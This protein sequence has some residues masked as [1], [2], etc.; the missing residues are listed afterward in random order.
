MKH[1]AK[2][3]NSRENGRTWSELGICGLPE[4]DGGR[5]RDRTCDP[6]DVNDT[7]EN[8]MIEFIDL[9]EFRPRTSVDPERPG[10]IRLTMRASGQ[11]W[12][13]IPDFFNGL[14]S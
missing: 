8:Q 9:F 12:N 6:L 7:I 11:Y 3:L 10:Q 5:D 14:V 13:G 2:A 4:R 1:R